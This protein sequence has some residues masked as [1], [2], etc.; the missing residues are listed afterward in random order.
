M[1]VAVETPRADDGDV[2]KGQSAAQFPESGSI[3]AFS[4]KKEQD[5]IHV[6]RLHYI[7]Y[8]ASVQ[9]DPLGTSPSG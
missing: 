4:R 7:R 3:A 2:E 6:V 9:H 1:Y 5:A 8:K